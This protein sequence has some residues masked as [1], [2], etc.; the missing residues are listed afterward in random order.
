MH[1][2]LRRLDG[3]LGDGARSERPL[4]EGNDALGRVRALDV[5]R[6]HVPAALEDAQLDVVRAG[7]SRLVALP[8]PQATDA[9]SPGRELAIR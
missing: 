3:R 7:P 6:D 9:P 1:G 8:Q 5:D 4:E 2:R